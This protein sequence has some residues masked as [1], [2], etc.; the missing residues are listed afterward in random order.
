M[1]FSSAATRV[2]GLNAEPGWRWPCVA[3]LN[4]RFSKS[5]PPTIARTPPVSLSIATSA[6]LGPMPP[7][8]PAIACSA[9]FWKSRS[10]VV[11]IF[12]PPPKVFPLP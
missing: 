3:R 12:S 4:G 9:A 11:R 6:A 7:S 1:P 2:N 8:R 5:E 10:S